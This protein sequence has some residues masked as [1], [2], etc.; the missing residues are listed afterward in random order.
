MKYTYSEILRR[1]KDVPRKG[2]AEHQIRDLIDTLWR[3]DFINRTSGFDVAGGPD[4]IISFDPATRILRIEPANRRFAF[5]Q[6]IFKIA[7]FK[8]NNPE[9]I[10]LPDEEGLYL[11]YIF[12]DQEDP[13]RKSQRL[14]LIKNPTEAQI[15]EVYLNRVSVAWLYW[16]ATNKKAVYFGDE[17]HGSE[18]NP[19]IH[20]WAHNAL[21]ALWKKGLQATTIILGDGSS[22]SHAQF[23]IASGE[24]YHEDMVHAIA[25]VTSTTGLPVLWF[26]GNNP[27]IEIN[28]GYSF[29]RGTYL[30]YN[31]GGSKIQVTDKY[32]V[33]YHVFTTNCLQYPLI[34]VMG[35][36]QYQNKNTACKAARLEMEALREK[37]PQQTRLPLASFV[38]EVNSEFTNTV[39]ARI[40]EPCT[41]Q[42]CFIWI[43]IYLNWY[44]ILIQIEL[45]EAGPG[46]DGITP[47][48]GQNGNWFIGQTDTGVP[49]EGQPG[50]D[51]QDGYTPVKGVD[52][53]DGLNGQPGSDGVTPHIGANG[54][55]FIGLTDTGVPAEGQPGADGQDGYTP[56]KG[57]DYFDGEDG[58]P[59]SDGITPHIGTNGN[60]FIGQTDTGVP[61][62]GQ[63]GAGGQDGYTPVKGVD[64]F[65]GEDGENGREVE[66]SVVE[67]YIVW[68]Y[69]GDQTWTDLVALAAITG[70]PGAAGQDG[71]HG[72]DG[73]Q[74]ELRT[75]AGW[76]EWRYQGEQ[77]WTQ[78]YQIPEGGG[79]GGSDTNIDIHILFEE[80]ES[81]TYICPYAMKL[82]AESASASISSD[83]SVNDT[84]LQYD[85]I[86]ITASAAGLI[87]LTFEI[88]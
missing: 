1:L 38:F 25:G 34:S 20:W 64:Y 77:T 53:F 75:N 9:E 69:Q 41:G 42:G 39:K 60:W 73:K 5:W 22:N 12:R 54:N 84:F 3:E 21:N 6:F 80:P 65:D 43:D 50:A 13:A 27:R 2:W 44:D 4:S 71:T 66:F 35:P 29:L 32:F 70:P 8:R 56:V 88:L 59:G 18:W 83:A 45:E 7:Y 55:W 28:P 37:L 58:Q 82:L 11:V 74:I 81:M 72:I 36:N 78:L 47:H 76:V 79:G 51:G 63:P 23:G 26:S 15:R 33:I 30:Y 85:E 67:E 16:D 14:F 46:K 19:Q 86:E 48:I 52:Y 57:V 87:T 49:A 61:A 31:G 62:E 17:R 24:F 68:R 40:V 10:E